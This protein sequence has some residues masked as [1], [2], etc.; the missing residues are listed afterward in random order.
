MKAGTCGG[1]PYFKFFAR[2]ARATSQAAAA[3]VSS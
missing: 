3:F 2:N 1:V